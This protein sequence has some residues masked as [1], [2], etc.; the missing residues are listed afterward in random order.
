MFIVF[1]FR[2]Y[3]FRQPFLMVGDPDMIKEILIK[4][5]PMFHDRRVRLFCTHQLLTT[6]LQSAT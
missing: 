6:I 1:Y 5:F 4:K 3:F 2:M